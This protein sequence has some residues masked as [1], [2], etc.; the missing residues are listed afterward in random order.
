MSGP[1]SGLLPDSAEL[2]GSCAWEND[3]HAT[4]SGA[5]KDMYKSRRYR[6]IGQVRKAA[7]EGCW[8][9]GLYLA[10]VEGF[11]APGDPDFVAGPGEFYLRYDAE[12]FTIQGQTR[13][14]ILQI[15]SAE[16]QPQVYRF[17][18]SA[19]LPSRASSAGTYKFVKDCLDECV[20]NHITCRKASQGLDERWPK[21]ILEIDPASSQVR[22]VGFDESMDQRYTALSYCWGSGEPPLQAT[23]TTLP[24]LKDGVSTG[25]LPRTIEDAVRFSLRIGSNLIWIDSMCI[26]QNDP[27]DWDEESCKMSTVYRHA[28]LTIVA[29]SAAS[30][31]EGFLERERDASILLREV[32]LGDRWTEIRARKVPQTGH[33][34]PYRFDCS[35]DQRHLEPVD[36]RGWTLQER[37]L[38]PRSIVVTAGEAQW[39]CQATQ[40]CECGQAPSEVTTSKTSTSEDEWFRVLG[41]YMTRNLTKDTDRLIALAGVSKVMAR[42]LPGKFSAGIWVTPEPTSLTMRGLLWCRMADIM[43]PSY[44]PREYLAPSWSWASVVGEATHVQAS[45]FS[46]CS[47]LSRILEVDITTATAEPFGKVAF[48]FMRMEGTL[49]RTTMR[50]KPSPQWKGSAATLTFPGGSSCH[51]DVPLERVQM[52]DGG[53]TVQRRA[54]LNMEDSDNLFSVLE[55][56]ETDVYVLPMIKYSTDYGTRWIEGL[57]L[58]RSPTLPGYQRLGTMSFPSEHTESA[59]TNVSEEFCI[60]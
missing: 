8:P 16:E 3:N 40:A 43:R 58:G 46:S 17:P 39:A 49:L 18:R 5:G 55:F 29:N 23:E 21:R 53:F 22:L 20:R 37:L 35:P 26:I 4:T 6:R 31:N 15:Y 41:D 10:A 56:P 32:Q 36:T 45:K 7:E 38:S 11:W 59:Q 50:W 47:Y 33:H 24:V 14:P 52:P 25:A 54:A 12:R 2:C 27:A 13:H 60:F 42:S 48:G 44:S 1:A 51:V 57:I 9:C 28:L 34:R 19:E 30:C